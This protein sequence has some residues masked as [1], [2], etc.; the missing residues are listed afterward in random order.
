M[1][2]LLWYTVESTQVSCQTSSHSCCSLHNYL[3]ASS[4]T[5]RIVSTPWAMKH[6]GLFF[7]RPNR[8]VKCVKCWFKNFCTGIV[9]DILYVFIIKLV[10]KQCRI[11]GRP[12]ANTKC[13]A[14]LTPSPPL[15]FRP[16][17]VGP[18]KYSKGVWGS[19]VSSPSG[20]WGRAPAEIKLVH[21]TLKIWIWWH[22]FY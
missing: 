5:L 9:I 6:C 22:Q 2:L 14:L 11:N 10:C 15:P 20:V 12:C 18:L 13:G 3:L 4:F 16:L 8:C 17:E 7:D 1:L 19:A 21:F